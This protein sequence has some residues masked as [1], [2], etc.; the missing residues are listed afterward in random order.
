MA[1]GAGRLA[2]GETASP[3]RQAWLSM[4]L[5]RAN[6]AVATIAAAGF[7][8]IPARPPSTA[9]TR[10]SRHLFLANP[11]ALFCLTARPRPRPTLL[12]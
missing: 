7:A 11:P 4:P 1:P 6:A 9:L 12:T 10:E 5:P 3:S 8:R 2:A